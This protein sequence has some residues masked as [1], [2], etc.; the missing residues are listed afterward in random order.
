M[1]NL[2]VVAVAREL[3]RWLVLRLASVSGVNAGWWVMSLSAAVVG[4]LSA[5]VV[6]T[7]VHFSLKPMPGELRVRSHQSPEFS[8]GGST[9]KA[10]GPEQEGKK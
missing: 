6:V 4:A 8:Q 9:V 2:R 10:P 3:P 7:L 5:V 1:T